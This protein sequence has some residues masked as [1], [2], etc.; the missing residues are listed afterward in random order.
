MEKHTLHSL[1]EVTMIFGSQRAIAKLLG[2]TDQA[3]CNMVRRGAFSATSRDLMQDELRRLG[4]SAPG[5]LW[6]QLPT[7]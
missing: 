1:A 5:H 6:R 4:H 3:V 2:V 7:K